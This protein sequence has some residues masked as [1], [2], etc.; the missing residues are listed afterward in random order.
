[1]SVVDDTRIPGTDSAT[2]WAPSSLHQPIATG[3]LDDAHSP[4]NE[5]ELVG[6]PFLV[7]AMSLS[8][9]VPTDAVS[10]EELCM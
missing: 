6:N 2:P 1:M 10:V 3:A 7:S 9:A 5:F 8:H 4:D